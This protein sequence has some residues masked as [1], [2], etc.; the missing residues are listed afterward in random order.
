M[1]QVLVIDD[2]VSVGAAIRTLLGRHAF[3]ATLA[4]NGH[5]GIELFDGSAFDL[6]IVDIFM[7]DIDGLQIIR[8]LRRRAPDVPILAISGFRFQ[9]AAGPTPDYLALAMKLGARGVLRKP[10]DPEQLM[11]AVNTCLAA[12]SGPA[13]A[14]D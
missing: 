2:D 4:D 12:G 10:F 3:A 9:N 1:K 6:V 5:T 8:E 11:T 14:R 7:P 13:A